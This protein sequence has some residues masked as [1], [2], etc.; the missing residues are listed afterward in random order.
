MFSS[1]KPDIP[2]GRNSSNP[3]DVTFVFDQVTSD[4]VGPNFLRNAMAAEFGFRLLDAQGNE[5]SITGTC[6]TGVG[7]FAPLIVQQHN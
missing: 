5:T 6:S 1:P 4:K 3:V 7:S 2:V